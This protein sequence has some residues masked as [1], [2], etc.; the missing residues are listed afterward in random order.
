MTYGMSLLG[1]RDGLVL[2]RTNQNPKANATTGKTIHQ[3]RTERIH[4][5][6]GEK[7]VVTGGSS[8]GVFAAS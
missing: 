7:G 6:N 2:M 1:S 8:V 5:K 3:V 4:S